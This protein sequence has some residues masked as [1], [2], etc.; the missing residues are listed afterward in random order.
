LHATL[1]E[2]DEVHVVFQQDTC[3]LG[4]IELETFMSEQDKLCILNGDI[5]AYDV[6]D[7]DVNGL[8][9]HDQLFE[10]FLFVPENEHVRVS[11][12]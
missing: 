5:H 4:F 10:T 11:D 3:A 9:G 7:V 8:V 2:M 1:A 6:V 12:I